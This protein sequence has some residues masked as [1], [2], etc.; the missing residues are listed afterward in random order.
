MTLWSVFCVP[1]VSSASSSCESAVNGREEKSQRTHFEQ[2]VLLYISH[3]YFYTFEMQL[4][5][6]EM[7]PSS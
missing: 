4:I 2:R 5:A 7:F 1:I 6:I 3:S